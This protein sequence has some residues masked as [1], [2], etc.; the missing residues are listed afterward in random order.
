MA[1][2]AVTGRQRGG[3]GGGERQGVEKRWA[4]RSGRE[5]K[6]RKMSAA[7]KLWIEEEGW[8]T[9]RSKKRGQSKATTN[10]TTTCGVQLTNRDVAT[11]AWITEQYAVRTDVIRWLLGPAQPLSDSRTRAVVARWQRAG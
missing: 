1:V 11:I 7:S 3:G 2:S 4:G 10:A 9:N 8:S 5:R 6:K